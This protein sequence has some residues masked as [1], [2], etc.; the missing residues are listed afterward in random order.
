MK[1]REFLQKISG[2]AKILQESDIIQ[3]TMK[4]SE[5]GKRTFKEGSDWSHTIYDYFFT[6]SNKQQNLYINSQ[7]ACHWGLEREVTVQYNG[8]TVLI[9]KQCAK[10]EVKP[11]GYEY[12]VPQNNS[13]NSTGTLS[14]YVNQSDSSYKVTLYNKG[15][16]EELIS[17][18]ENG[19][20][21]KY[22]EPIVKVEKEIN[23]TEVNLLEKNFSF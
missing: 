5:Q 22:V 23:L 2:I 14:I 4:L 17:K 1:E 8:E 16:W 7:E 18:I 13:I 6:S 3:R 15:H 9:A 19:S 12:F 21:E 20:I 11:S 10:N